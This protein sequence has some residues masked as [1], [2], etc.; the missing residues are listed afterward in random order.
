MVM[1]ECGGRKDEL[2][3]VLEFCRA[4]KV[5]FASATTGTLCNAAKQASLLNDN[6]I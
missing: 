6:A 1:P 2:E 3:V 5:S 4:V